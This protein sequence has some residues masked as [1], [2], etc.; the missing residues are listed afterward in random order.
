MDTFGWF[1]MKQDKESQQN[2]F[3]YP[4]AHM[5]IVSKSE[6]MDIE[7]N[8]PEKWWNQQHSTRKWKKYPMAKTENIRFLPHSLVFLH[9]HM[10]MSYQ[11]LTINKNGNN[12]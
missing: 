2:K 12:R 3:I 7:N 1:C 5:A 9:I 11:E 8:E 4:T 10:N 6:Y